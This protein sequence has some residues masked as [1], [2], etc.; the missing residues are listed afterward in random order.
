M[1]WFYFS[2]VLREHL[3]V[4]ERVERA[5]RIRRAQQHKQ[6]TKSA[7]R[8]A[9]ARSSVEKDTALRPTFEVFSFP[10]STKFTRNFTASFEAVRD[11]WVC[12]YVCVWV[13]VCLCDKPLLRAFVLGS[14]N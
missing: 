3:A 7:K 9:R 4:W 8:E 12:V 1:T 6:E 13:R 11:V 5:N 14:N 10:R 2:C